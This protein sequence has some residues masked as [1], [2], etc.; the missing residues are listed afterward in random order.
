MKS[1]SVDAFIMRSSSERAD[2][3]FKATLY[4]GATLLF[5]GNSLLLDLKDEL[6]INICGDQIVRIILEKINASD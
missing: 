4:G 3:L 5:D 6:K 2:I 1:N